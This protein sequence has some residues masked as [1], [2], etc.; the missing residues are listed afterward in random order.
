M[1]LNSYQCLC[2]LEFF[3]EM[4]LANITTR[5]RYQDLLFYLPGKKDKDRSHDIA[6]VCFV[7]EH[8]HLARTDYRLQYEHEKNFGLP[9]PASAETKISFVIVLTI[10]H[11][12]LFVQEYCNEE[13][14]FCK[15][16]CFS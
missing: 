14:L 16:N 13:A 5:G 2:R 1:S 9:I 8:R 10:Y 15:P 6:W 4:I 11:F 7:Q 3:N 12:L